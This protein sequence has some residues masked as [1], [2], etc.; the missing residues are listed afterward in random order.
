MDSRLTLRRYSIFSFEK[1]GKPVNIKRK[2][3][4]GFSSWAFRILLISHMSF[5]KLLIITFP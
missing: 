4:R 5:H 2:R 3:P 1:M